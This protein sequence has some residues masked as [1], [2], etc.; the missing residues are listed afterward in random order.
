[1]CVQRKCRGLESCKVAI[2]NCMWRR[3]TRS[4]THSHPFQVS[5]PNPRTLSHKSSFIPRACNSW[6]V[7]PSPSFPECYNLP[8][9]KHMTNKLDLISLSSWPFTFF[10]I[11]LLGLGTGHH[12]LSPTQLTQ[13][14]DLP[15]LKSCTRFC[16]CTAHKVQASLGL[17]RP[18]LH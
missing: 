2:E 13:S 12:D 9:F 5:L 16:D 7:L 15:S 8:S 1:M 4:S 6:N 14:Y 3:D 18:A 17:S 10:F 11:P